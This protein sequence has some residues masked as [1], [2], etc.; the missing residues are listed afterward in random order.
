MKRTLDWLRWLWPL[1]HRLLLFLAVPLLPWLLLALGIVGQPKATVC[2]TWTGLVCQGAGFWTVWSE[3]RS[4]LRQHGRPGWRAQVC[5]WWSERPG[6]GRKVVAGT[7]VVRV[8]ATS[9]ARARITQGKGDGSTEARLSALENNLQSLQMELDNERKESQLVARA[10]E[11][12]LKEEASARSAARSDLT[13]R[14][15]DQAV[16]SAGLQFTGLWLFLL[17]SFYSSI[18]SDL[19]SALPWLGLVGG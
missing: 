14:I 17:G 10:L 18:P 7:G 5:Q 15:E 16:G 2:F 3:I 19:A 6:T 1:L 13:K 4:A 12:R 9:S 8:N 11:A